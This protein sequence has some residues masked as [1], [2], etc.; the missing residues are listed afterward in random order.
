M[1]QSFHDLVLK[2]RERWLFKLTLINVRRKIN[3]QFGILKKA[4]ELCYASAARS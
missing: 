1:P 4:V 3:S 2:I